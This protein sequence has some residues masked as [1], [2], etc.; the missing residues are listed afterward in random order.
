MPFNTLRR[1]QLLHVDW[2]TG[3]VSKRVL[4]LPACLISCFSFCCTSRIVMD[5]HWFFWRC[6]DTIPLA[7]QHSI[8]I[9][10]CIQSTYLIWLFPHFGNILHQRCCLWRL[11]PNDT[12][13][14]V[15][16]WLETEWET[17]WQQAILEYCLLYC[18]NTC[19]H[20]IVLKYMHSTHIFNIQVLH[21][22]WKRG[23]KAI[24]VISMVE[25]GWSDVLIHTNNVCLSYTKRIPYQVGV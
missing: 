25:R 15:W 21:C 22:L 1:S 2:L 6:I 9:E 7:I 14:K 4:Y 5:G 17:L 10:L 19:S 11:C 12:Q 18:Y 8:S 20:L 13:D 16:V 3:K 24:V 23:L